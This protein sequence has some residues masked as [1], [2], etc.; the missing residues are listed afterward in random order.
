MKSVTLL[1]SGGID[2]SALVDFYLKRKADLQCIHFQYGQASAQSEKKA[3]TEIAKHYGV[4]IRFIDFGFDLKTHHYEAY[5]RN[6][7]FALIAA[8]TTTSPGRIAIGIHSG[9]PYYDSGSYFLKDCQRILDGYFAGVVRIEAPFINLT[10]S[11]IISYCRHNNVPIEL[12]YS[13][14]RSEI[15]PCHECPSCK[16]RD[17]LL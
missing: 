11:D 6:A 2:S 4:S 13:C 7:L 1:A 17:S 12:T 9:S 14:Q 8:S 3:A 15:H 16:E 10:K 5:G